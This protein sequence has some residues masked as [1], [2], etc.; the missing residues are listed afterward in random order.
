MKTLS[1]IPA[2]L[3][4]AFA[5]GSAAAEIIP[6][7]GTWQQTLAARDLDGNWANGPEAWFDRT[8]GITWLADPQAISG[9]RWDTYFRGSA[10]ENGPYNESDEFDGRSLLSDAFFWLNQLSLGGVSGWRLPS[11]D[12]IN[13]QSYRYSG[14]A[15]ASVYSGQIDVGWNIASPQSELAHMFTVTLGNRGAFDSSGNPRASWERTFNTGVFSNLKPRK[16]WS[17]SR[18]SSS[19]NDVAW[20][21]EMADGKQQGGFS[22]IPAYPDAYHVWAVH[23]GD[24]GSAMTPVPEPAAWM[25][26]AGGVL[27]L[28][29]L[30]RRRKV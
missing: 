9:T 15:G 8:L 7:Q 26:M 17:G 22:P 24:V 30:R 23:D 25:S 6:G 21:F 3:A 1:S 11:T 10:G 13:G 4:L 12:P 5:V 14:N 20:V 29:W 16:Y 19:V 27:A 18:Y 28:A 2:G